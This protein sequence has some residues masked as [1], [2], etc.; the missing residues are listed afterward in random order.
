MSKKLELVNHS[1][2]LLQYHSV[3][4]CTQQVHSSAIKKV[5]SIA[6]RDKKIQY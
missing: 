4:C 1:A 3:A 2:W 6:R 5:H